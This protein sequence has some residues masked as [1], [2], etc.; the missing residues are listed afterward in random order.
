MA[1]SGRGMGGTWENAKDELEGHRDRTTGEIEGLNPER[2]KYLEDLIKDAEKRKADAD[3]DTPGGGQTSTG[4]STRTT[5]HRP[6]YDRTNN[7]GIIGALELS[8][9]PHARAQELQN[10][11]IVLQGRSY[12]IVG[13]TGDKYLLPSPEQAALDKAL[14]Y[15]GTIS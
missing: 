13:N 3:S 8:V 11:R 9:I 6:G 7:R 2:Q 5:V 14:G 10:G 4:G 12:D 15:K 1:P